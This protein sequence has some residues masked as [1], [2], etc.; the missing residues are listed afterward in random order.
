MNF[1]LINRVT[2]TDST[3]LLSGPGSQVWTRGFGEGAS[4]RQGDSNPGTRQLQ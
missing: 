3:L 2:G 1:V 4:R